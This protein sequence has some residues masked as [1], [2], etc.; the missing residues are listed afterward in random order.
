VKYRTGYDLTK[1]DH[2]E[3]YLVLKDNKIVIKPENV[4]CH[5]DN[6]FNGNKLLGEFGN[7]AV[8]K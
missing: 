6:L 4:T 2:G 7:F 3:V 8:T 5:L 1:L